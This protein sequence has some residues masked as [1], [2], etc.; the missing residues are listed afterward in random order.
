MSE[1]ID[2]S[3][4]K[5]LKEHDHTLTE[6]NFKSKVLFVSAAD[7][8]IRQVIGKPD[9]EFLDLFRS[10]IPNEIVDDLIVRGVDLSHCL[11]DLNILSKIETMIG[12]KTVIFSP[13]QTEVNPVGWL[14]AFNMVDCMFSSPEMNTESKARAFSI[15]LFLKLRDILRT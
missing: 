5:Y 12:L 9:Y 10:R 14:V 15:L 4:I 7:E 2:L 13:T 1:I 11:E 8:I 3:N 6:K